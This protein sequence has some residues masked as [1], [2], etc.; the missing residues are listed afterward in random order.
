MLDTQS[1]TVCVRRPFS[2]LF[3]LFMGPVH[4]FAILTFQGAYKLCNCCS[5]SDFI[6]H[7]QCMY[8]HVYCTGYSF[9]P[10]LS[11]SRITGSSFSKAQC[12]ALLHHVPH[13]CQVIKHSSS[14]PKT[15]LSM[16]PFDAT[17]VVLRGSSMYSFN[18][19]PKLFFCCF[20]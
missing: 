2:P 15:L 11:T 5:T 13:N 20:L 18:I 17:L 6:I 7:I 1:L 8:Y 10:Q 9:T 16:L 3:S 4:L 14:S 12:N 19:K